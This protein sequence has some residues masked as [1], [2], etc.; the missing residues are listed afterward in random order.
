IID[1]GCGMGNVLSQLR[2]AYSCCT[3][4]IEMQDKC[5]KAVKLMICEAGYCI[6]F[7]RALMV[8]NSITIEYGNMLENPNLWQL[9]SDA[10][11]VFVNNLM[12]KATRKSLSVIR[13][14]EIMFP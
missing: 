9:I 5:I 8:V 6:N 13:I 4:G 14:K 1:L 7:W 10:N 11:V 12:F 3:Y 2:M